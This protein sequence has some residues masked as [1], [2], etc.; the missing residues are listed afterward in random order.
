LLVGDHPLVGDLGP[1]TECRF[2]VA[3]RAVGRPDPGRRFRARLG[4]GGQ[5]ELELAELLLGQRR[6]LVRVVLTAGE[7]APEQDLE[8]AGDRDVALPCPRRARTRS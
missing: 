3:D 6:A 5:L 1:L 2:G 8:F 7:L 4:G